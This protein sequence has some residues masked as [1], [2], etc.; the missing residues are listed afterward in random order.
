MRDTDRHRRDLVRHYLE[1]K[2][3]ESSTVAP[4]MEEMLVEMAEGCR[5]PEARI[6]EEG[7]AWFWFGS[8][9]EAVSCFGSKEWSWGSHLIF[10]AVM[11]AASIPLTV[12]HNV[13][14]GYLK[15]RLLRWCRKPIVDELERAGNRLTDVLFTEEVAALADA[16]NS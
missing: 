15:P 11:W 3:V 9:V 12:I 4:E 7:Y 1:A 8:G 2:G 14:W 16:G 6:C 13:A 5:R 10:V